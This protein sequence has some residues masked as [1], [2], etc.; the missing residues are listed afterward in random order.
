MVVSNIF[1]FHPHLGHLGKIWGRFPIWIIFFK[2]VGSTTNQFRH[3]HGCVLLLC[4][5]SGS[6]KTT[7]GFDPGKT[8]STDH[9]RRLHITYLR[10]W[11]NTWVRW[12][13]SEW[14]SLTDAHVTN[15]CCEFSWTKHIRMGN[16]G[17]PSFLSQDRLKK[18]LLSLKLRAEAKNEHIIPLKYCWWKK[19]CTTKAVFET[20]ENTGISTTNLNWWV[21]RISGCH[22]PLSGWK[23][24]FL[25]KWFPSP[26][27]NIRQLLIGRAWR[28]GVCC[29]RSWAQ[30]LHVNW[31]VCGCWL[32]GKMM[33]VS[34][35]KGEP[36][37]IGYPETLQD[38]YILQGG[39]ILLENIIFWKQEHQG[40]QYMVCMAAWCSHNKIGSRHF[41]PDVPSLKVK[42]SLKTIGLSSLPT[43]D[44]QGNFLVSG[45]GY[46][47]V[48]RP[49]PEHTWGIIPASKWSTTMV[50]KSPSWGGSPSKWPFHGL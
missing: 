3:V 31:T 29:C 8:K 4:W 17:T 50:S 23:I 28:G 35:E 38:N 2:W 45:S 27:V 32:L 22:R 46:L 34:W 6:G 15:L 24:V 40:F 47:D 5:N 26:R 33:E 7:H 48:S 10:P 44:F 30:P 42:H 21:Y 39:Y 9:P 12:T 20:L 49:S 13:E 19:S 16:L 18:A 36:Y 43:I 1:Y 11:Y 14:S 25:L 37:A 41:F